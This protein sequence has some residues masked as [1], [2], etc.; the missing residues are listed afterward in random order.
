M[1]NAYDDSMI[2][3]HIRKKDG[4]PQPLKKH[5]RAVSTLAGR[6]LLPMKLEAI[7]ELAGLLHDMGKSTIAFQKYLRN[8]VAQNDYEHTQTCPHAPIGAIFANDRWF[9]Q[10]G[11][12]GKWT[13]QIV[14]IA[15]YGHHAGLP[16]CLNEKGVS[17]YLRFFSPKGKEELHYDEAVCNYLRE[18]V[19]LEELD[20]LFSHAYA[21]IENIKGYLDKEDAGFQLGMIARTVLSAVV[22]AD[23]W[24]SACFEHNADSLAC[25]KTDLN[26]NELLARFEAYSIRTFTQQSA[27]NDIRTAIS[28]DC[29]R[30]ASFE[31]G[32]FTLTVP[33]GGGKTFSTLRFALRHAT[34]ASM[35]RIFY[36]I[37]FNTI[38]DQNAADIR[39][40]LDEYEGILEH[41]SGVVWGDEKEES[42]YCYL[43][44]RWNSQIILTSI[45]QFLN[46]LYRKEN[47][48]ARRMRSL[49]QSILIFDEVQALPKK[50]T[51]LFEKAIRF[52]VRFYGCTVILCTAT[53]PRFDLPAREMIGDVPWL[54]AQMHRVRYIDQSRPAIT[55]EDAVEKLA[56][57]V[58]RH[59]SV[60]VIVNTKAAVRE[61]F[62]RAQLLLKDQAA[63]F[64][65]STAMCPA[66]R[67]AILDT[68]K[69]RVSKGAHLPTLLVSTALIEAG[70]N[71]SFPA[72]IR[73]LTGLSSVIQAAGR[74]NRNAEE[75]TG[76][77]YLW[78]LADENLSRLPEIQKGQDLCDPFLK[79]HQAD[80]DQIGEPNVIGEYFLDERLGFEKILDYPFADWGTNLCDM[81]SKNGKCTGA[82]REAGTGEIGR[83]A[84]PQ[85]FRTAGDAFRVIDQN[86][87]PI[88]V[89]YGEGKEIIQA[90]SGEHDMREEI[91]L[92][93]R[94]QRFSVSV[95][96]PI[97]R[98]L[99]DRNALA[100]IGDT[101]VVAL[102]P[103]FYNEEIGIS[104]EPGE[105][106]LLNID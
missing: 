11:M 49:A 105:M 53:Q 68:V 94:A 91:R 61:I 55:N 85:S 43:T 58:N 79:R 45:V 3:A 54:F 4:V 25:E 12:I 69:K 96:D 92:I 27:L 42:E 104:I 83:L 99:E 64:H 57:L 31:P 102:R 10:G 44:E 66:H 39:A 19:D 41:H 36:I 6:S 48:D 63:C 47:T 56:E 51:R 13:A 88:L 59:G 89:P 67:L 73:S 82:A 52:L 72:V 21:E 90:L 101:G 23:R 15:I 24:D 60:L 87:W 32:I 38:L 33:T 95:Y 18:T 34:L 40:A 103:E 62:S 81:L 97:R 70:I 17:P 1:I 74:C 20:A 7:G 8:A 35:Q 78:K 65:L 106:E 75:E 46:A 14:S 77:V 16:D 5:C 71:I 86:T 98:A 93:R 76:T 28:L 100:R 26:W 9:E 30:R 80:I 2:L 50:C 29:L 84:L 22:D 37:P